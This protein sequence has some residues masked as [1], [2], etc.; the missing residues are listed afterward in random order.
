MPRYGRLAQVIGPDVEKTIES[1]LLWFIIGIG[2]IIGSFLYL[3][4]KIQSAFPNQ[5]FIQSYLFSLQTQ[6]IQILI[7]SLFLFV[8]IFIVFM[9]VIF[10]MPIKQIPYI[11]P[12]TKVRYESKKPS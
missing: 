2:M 9:A 1:P 4:T 6:K 5:S 7:V 12:I 8:G 3:F 11:N 10:A